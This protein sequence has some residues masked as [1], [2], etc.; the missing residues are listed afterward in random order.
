MDEKEVRD[1]SRSGSIH[2]LLV[3]SPFLFCCCSGR[4]YYREY[5]LGKLLR[6]IEGD[7]LK[8]LLQ[9]DMATRV[10]K[11]GEQRGKN[12]SWKYPEEHDDTFE[13][14]TCDEFGRSTIEPLQST[15]Q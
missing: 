2:Q 13:S 14:K 4:I 5:R 12:V 6:E 15:E 9:Q 7:E 11:R 8:Q 3:I 10:N 1:S